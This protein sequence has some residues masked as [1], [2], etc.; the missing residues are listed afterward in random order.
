MRS[1]IHNGKDDNACN[2]T[3]CSI[4]YKY[5][6][7]TL[8]GW[9]QP[10]AAIL[11]GSQKHANRFK[12]KQKNCKRLRKNT[13][14]KSRNAC[15]NLPKTCKFCR[16]LASTCKNDKRNLQ[17]LQNKYEKFARKNSVPLVFQDSVKIVAKS[18]CLKDVLS[19]L[20]FFASGNQCSISVPSVFH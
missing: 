4:L 14:N 18:I 13:C 17:K 11:R 8:R 12:K 19:V 10:L 6:Y 16:M 2:V 1:S 9:A 15:N 3:S 5:V 7:Q 20:R